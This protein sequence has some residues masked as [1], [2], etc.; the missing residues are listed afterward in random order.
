[1]HASQGK[2][3]PLIQTRSRTRAHSKTSSHFVITSSI[4]MCMIQKDYSFRDFSESS[5]QCASGSLFRYAK[6]ASSY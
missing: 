3:S 1:M 5:S 2:T 4:M 6:E